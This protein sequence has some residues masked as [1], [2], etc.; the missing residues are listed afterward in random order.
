MECQTSTTFYDLNANIGIVPEGS[1]SSGRTSQQE[2]AHLANKVPTTGSNTAIKSADPAPAVQLTVSAESPLPAPVVLTLNQDPIPVVLT[3]QVYKRIIIRKSAIS[4]SINTYGARII[5]SSSF[6][7][8]SVFAGG[9]DA[10]S[11]SGASAAGRSARPG[12]FPG[13]LGLCHR[14]LSFIPALTS[15][16]VHAAAA[17]TTDADYKRKNCINFGILLL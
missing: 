3:H 7:F 15:D 8:L 12:A 14:F 17:A 9:R 6:S 4:Q 16:A 10:A 1:S 13:H 5:I 11:G 2:A